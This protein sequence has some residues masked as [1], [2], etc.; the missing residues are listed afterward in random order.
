M[1]DMFASA[2]DPCISLKQRFKVR[3]ARAAS[4]IAERTTC[5]PDTCQASMHARVCVCVRRR[6]SQRANPSQ[7][8]APSLMCHL[9]CSRGSV[10]SVK[11]AKSDG[12]DGGEGL[13]AVSRLSFVDMAGAERANRTGNSGQRFKESVKINGSL[14]ALGRCLEALRHNQM[15]P[16]ECSRVHVKQRW[17]VWSESSQD[18]TSQVGKC[19][20]GGSASDASPR[21]RVYTRC[22][23]AYFA[24]PIG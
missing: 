11:S 13:L 3:E 2:Y 14:L 8:P 6:F 24:L 5:T 7:S 21:Q 23:A 22:P 9:S 1:T 19:E 15:N 18:I 12:G 10:N 4:P 20:A 16:S 17:R